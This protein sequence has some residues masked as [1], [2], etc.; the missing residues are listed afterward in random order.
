MT[1]KPNRLPVRVCVVLAA[2]SQCLCSLVVAADPPAREESWSILFLGGKKI[3]HCQSVVENVKQNGVPL[4]KTSTV[5]DMKINRETQALVLK[6]VLTTEETPSGDLLKF[7]WEL[8]NPP[9]SVQLTHGKIDGSK[10]TLTQEVNGKGRTSTQLWKTGVKSSVYQDRALKENPL[11]PGES[12][13]FEYFN[14]EFAKID[15]ITFNA[16]GNQEVK[17]LD[18]K[19]Q[20]LLKVTS[21]QTLLPGLVTESYLDNEGETVKVSQN[22]LGSTMEMFRATKEEALRP[23]DG[24]LFDLAVNTLVKV[25]PIPKCY[26]TK[27]VVYRVSIAGQNPADVIPVGNTQSVKKIDA[28]TIELTVV[29]VPI[30]ASAQLTPIAPE[31]LES[32]QYLQKDDERVIEHA[33][34]AAGDATDP[35]EIARRMEKYVQQKVASKN[36]ATALASAAEVAQSLEGDCTEHAV[37]LAAMLRVKGIPSRV[38]VGLLYVERLSAFGGHMWTEANLNGQW[39]PLDA[40]LGMGRVDAVHLKLSDA[41]MSDRGPMVI[42]GFAPMMTIIGKLK[43][44]VISSE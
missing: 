29:S 1:A 33:N 42:S 26:Q 9:A 6:Q 41:S 25:N 12:R 35:A 37:L 31:F 10:L 19:T 27:R 13:S 18:G 20:R 8:A 24:E 30:P 15:L 36:L 2:L 11:K 17:L 28:E 34:R 3:G 21:T 14:P 22:V 38:T 44:D 7:R 23:A 40:T 16:I 5:I 39:I 32:S 4:I 43:L